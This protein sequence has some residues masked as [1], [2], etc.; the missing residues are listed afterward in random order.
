MKLY[1]DK[2]WLQEK[3]NELKYAQTIGKEIGVSGDTIEYWRKKFGIPK[4][5]DNQARRKYKYNQDFFEV[6]DTEEKA[7][8]LGFIMADGCINRNDSSKP[9]N[10]V[11]I[12]LKIDDIKHLEKFNN[13][14][15]STHPI[16]TKEVNSKNHISLMCSLRLNTKKMCDDLIKLGVTPNKT[17]KEVIPK[18]QNDLIRHFVRGYFDGDGCLYKQGEKLNCSICSSS[19]NLIYQI[20]EIMIS[21]GIKPYIEERNN[22]SVPFFIIGTKK[23]SSVKTFLDYIY[24]D[25]T[26]YLD[27]KYHFYLSHF[28]PLDGDI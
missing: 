12:N 22:Y 3:F 14:I 5:N 23:Q 15:D 6:I 13:S 21:L 11:E 9:Y 4:Q 2:E 24:K 28:A 18:I 17:S 1:K 10:R 20:K 16:K 26:I 8:W 7:Y 25:S 19:E 27:R